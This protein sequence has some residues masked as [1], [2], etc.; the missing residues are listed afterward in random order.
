MK[1]AGLFILLACAIYFG[2]GSCSPIRGREMKEDVISLFGQT[3]AKSS[4]SNRNRLL[5]PSVADQFPFNKV[6]AWKQGTQ[7]S[8]PGK[9]RQ[10]QRRRLRRTFGYRTK[11]IP[12]K[13]LKC[14]MFKVGE[15]EKTFCVNYTASVCI[16]LDWMR[17]PL[18]LSLLE[19]Y[20][21]IMI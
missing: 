12:Q 14:K 15:K 5:S 13:K 21:M 9:D 7:P 16:A 11:C 3:I 19:M 8:A 18:G 17:D 1:S 6:E 20:L 10:Q 2:K 4:S